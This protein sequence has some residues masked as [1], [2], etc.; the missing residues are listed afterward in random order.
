MRWND[1]GYYLLTDKSFYHF[2]IRNAAKSAER[3]QKVV[4]KLSIVKSTCG[5]GALG[6]RAKARQDVF[7]RAFARPP[8]RMRYLPP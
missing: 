7:K 8:S 3:V 5:D 2:A 4:Q 1:G 6:G